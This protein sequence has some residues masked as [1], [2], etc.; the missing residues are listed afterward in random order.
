MWFRLLGV[1]V[2]AFAL[3]TAPGVVPVASATDS[4][5]VRTQSGKVRCLVNS[6]DIAH[7]GGPLVVCEYNSGFPQA[8]ATSGMHWNL[9]VVKAS[10]AF[11]WDTGNIGGSPEALASDVVLRYGQT[12]RL[13]SWTIVPT[14]EGTRF[15]NDRTGRG[16]FVSIDNVYAF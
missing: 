10:G 4:Q 13:N 11:N 8:P 5:S 2:T 16:M 12:Y 9:A 7:G 6:N 1:P 3:A 15:T 14:F